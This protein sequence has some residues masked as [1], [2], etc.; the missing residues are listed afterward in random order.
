MNAIEAIFS[1]DR[2]AVIHNHVI[3]CASNEERKRLFDECC[4]IMQYSTATIRWSEFMLTFH[5]GG[6]VRFV[7]VHDERDLYKILSLQV[8]GVWARTP[9]PFETELHAILRHRVKMF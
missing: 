6:I 1:A 8:H 5:Q 4:M 7:V 2:R 9:C 3:I